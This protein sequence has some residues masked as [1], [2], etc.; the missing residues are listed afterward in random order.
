MSQMTRQFDNADNDD[1]DDDDKSD[2]HVAT[3]RLLV[4][5]PLALHYR[6]L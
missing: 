4:I 5:V 2:N 6:F 3:C 1:N